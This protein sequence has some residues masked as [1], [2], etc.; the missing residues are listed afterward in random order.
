MYRRNGRRVLAVAS[1]A[2]VAATLALTACSSEEPAPDDLASN[3]AGSMDNYGVG[4]DFKATS[5]Q[6][7]EFSI[8]INDHPGYPFNEDWPFWQWLEEKTNV[9]STSCPPR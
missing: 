5:E 1:A 3:R 9:S 4:V 2:A 7:L 6:P 8:L